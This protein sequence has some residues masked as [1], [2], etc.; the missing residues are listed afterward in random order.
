M[1][2]LEFIT[3]LKGQ[4]DILK[5]NKHHMESLREKITELENNYKYLR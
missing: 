3:H 2:T 1:N 5:R 4:V